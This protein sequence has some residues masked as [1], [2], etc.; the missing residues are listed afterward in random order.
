MFEEKEKTTKVIRYAQNPTAF[1][2][3]RR[4]AEMCLLIQDMLEEH[5]VEEDENIQEIPLP[6][7]NAPILK[8]VIQYCEHHWNKPSKQIPKPLRKPF[9]CFI[10]EWDR[11]FLE[12]DNYT[13]VNLSKAA[14][15][16][17]LPD[18]LA[19]TCAKMATLIK[20]QSVRQIRTMFGIVN[21]LSEK[22]ER[23]LQEENRWHEVSYCKKEHEL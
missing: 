23:R 13:L 9:H 3:E 10:S 14:N 8:L 4:A 21:D 15:Y 18:L 2:A 5:D 7:V 12:V 17:N 6:N 19:L 1:T 16:L 22:E 11:K 20:R